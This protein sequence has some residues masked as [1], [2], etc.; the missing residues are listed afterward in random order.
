[1]ES[2]GIPPANLDAPMDM[3]RGFL[4]AARGMPQVGV[5]GKEEGAVS[6]LGS[7]MIN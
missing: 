2:F 4:A 3:L 7:I 1:M 5:N 6:F